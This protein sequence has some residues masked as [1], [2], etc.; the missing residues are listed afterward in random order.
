MALS[1]EDILGANDLP[2][3]DVPVPQWGGA[4][5]LRPMTMQEALDITKESPDALAA[6]ILVLTAVNDEGK[7]LFTA[8]D[9]PALSGKSSVA[10][11]GLLQKALELN[12]LGENSVKAAEKN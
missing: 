10:M 5:R 8:E 9:I 11:K 12:G 4:V 6:R 1:R 2:Y 3:E 7:H